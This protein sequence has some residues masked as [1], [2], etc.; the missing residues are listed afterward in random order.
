MF[1]N[2][3]SS[4]ASPFVDYV[5]QII[6]QPNDDKTSRRRNDIKNDLASV[7]TNYNI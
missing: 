5:K 2:E 4:Y 3:D 7:K 6:K 1:Q